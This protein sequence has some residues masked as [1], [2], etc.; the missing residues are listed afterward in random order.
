MH[1]PYTLPLFIEHIK[2]YHSKNYLLKLTGLPIL[3]SSYLLQSDVKSQKCTLLGVQLNVLK[4]AYTV[5]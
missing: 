2:Y 5:V 4:E 3:F 1:L